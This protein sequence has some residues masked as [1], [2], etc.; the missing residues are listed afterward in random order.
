MSQQSAISLWDRHS[1]QLIPATLYDELDTDEVLQAALSWKPLIEARTQ[2]LIADGTLRALWPQHIHWNWEVKASA[3][4]G[5]LA[6]QIMG[7]EAEGAMQGLMLV[8]TAGKVCH[9]SSQAGRPLVYVHFLATAPW[10][11]PVFVNQPRF[12]LVGKVFLAG[13]IQ[14]SRDNGFRGRVGLHSLPQAESF[15]YSCGMTDLDIDPAVENLHYFEMTPVQSQ[16]FL[17]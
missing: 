8:A 12:G 10:N 2:E 6:Y 17:P 5:L 1:R 7:I 16:A 9:I 15:Y 3:V 13:A 4:A 14:L 11:D